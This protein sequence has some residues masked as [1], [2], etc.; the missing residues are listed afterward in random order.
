MLRFSLFQNI[1]HGDLIHHRV[2][3]G[4]KKDF[5]SKSLRNF[6]ITLCLVSKCKAIFI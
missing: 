3:E 4:G 5:M 2:I 1:S 6:A